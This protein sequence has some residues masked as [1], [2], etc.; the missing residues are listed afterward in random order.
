VEALLD[1][2]NVPKALGELFQACGRLEKAPEQATPADAAGFTAVIQALGLQLP[3][4]K[5]E[6]AP[7]EILALAEKRMSARN[8]KDWAESDRLRDELAAKGWTV[9][10]V[11]GGFE[12]ER[13]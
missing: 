1:N 7:E 11:S 5:Q 13:G 8:T 3:E 6:Q 12:L 9:R 10:D 4:P 2:L